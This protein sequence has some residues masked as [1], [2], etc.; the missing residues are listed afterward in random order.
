MPSGALTK[1]LSFH[2]FKEKYAGHG[3]PLHV[4]GSGCPNDVSS[5][6][7][8]DWVVH[9]SV[10]FPLSELCIDSSKA[11]ADIAAEVQELRKEGLLCA[12]HA[13]TVATTIAG[14]A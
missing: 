12:T 8:S 6:D 10:D 3:S 11:E 14:S 5:P 7:F 2:N 1:N 9:L 13:N 4:R